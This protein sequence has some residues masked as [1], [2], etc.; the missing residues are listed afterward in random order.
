MTV[1][2]EVLKQETK[3]RS[4][5]TKQELKNEEELHRC[6]EWL[7]IAL[8]CA[9]DCGGAD[10]ASCQQCEGGHRDQASSVWG[11]GD[12]HHR[13]GVRTAYRMCVHACTRVCV[14][15]CVCTCVLRSTLILW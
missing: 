11:E 8:P 3:G 1:Q 14:C 5:V 4:L 13:E 7:T 6:T 10:S 15:V 2:T 9:L 12:L